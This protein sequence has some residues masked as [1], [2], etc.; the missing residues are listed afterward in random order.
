MSRK[1]ETRDAR[2]RPITRR[3][4]RAMEAEEAREKAP[5][6]KYCVLE[7]LKAAGRRLIPGDEFELDEISAESLVVG[8]IIEAVAARKARAT[9]KA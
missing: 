8:K 2:D 7:P 4:R 1:A 6:R 5:R 3:M 9:D